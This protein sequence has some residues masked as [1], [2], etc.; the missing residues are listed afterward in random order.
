MFK[1]SEKLLKTMK[2]LVSNRKL[3]YAGNVAYNCGGSCTGTC[4]GCDGT[5]VNG[6]ANG[7][8]SQNK[9]AIMWKE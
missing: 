8:V 7:C 6:C 5:C 2:G 9:Y 4:S 1:I 3:A